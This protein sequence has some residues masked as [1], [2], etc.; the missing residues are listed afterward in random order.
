[1]IHKYTLKNK[2]S[3]C[4]YFPKPKL[5]VCMAQGMDVSFLTVMATYHDHEHVYVKPRF[6][7]GSL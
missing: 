5:N 4:I 2:L 7:L 6:R 1:M 3:N